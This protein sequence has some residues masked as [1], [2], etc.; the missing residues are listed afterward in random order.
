MPPEIGNIYQV[1]RRSQPGINQVLSEESGPL[2]GEVEDH[3]TAPPEEAGVFLHRDDTTT[4]R[5]KRQNYRPS[6][7]S[8]GQ[9][10]FHNSVL[11]FLS[12]GGSF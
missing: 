3:V 2:T 1:L 8:V 4:L 10:G 5:T 12:S 7:A 6:V 9:R 11:H